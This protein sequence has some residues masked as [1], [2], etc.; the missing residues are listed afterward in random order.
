MTTYTWSANASGSWG[1]GADWTNQNDGTTGTPPSDLDTALINEAGITVTVGTLVAATAYILDTTGATLSVAGGTLTTE[2]L[3][4]F[5]GNVTVSAGTYYAG[6]MGAVF[7]QNLVQ[8]GG[9]IDAVTGALI[10]NDGSTLSGTLAGAGVLDF[11]GPNSNNYIDTGFK[12]NISSIEVTAGA[13]LGLNANF[14]FTHNLTVSNST[15]DLFGHTLTDSGAFALSGIAGDGTIADTGTLTLGTGN[16]TET[17]DDGLLL[18]VTGT[19][20]QANTIYLGA[21]D[22]GAKVMIGKTGHYNING[23]WTVGDPSSV[24]SISNLGVLAK[25]GGG[26]LAQIDTQVTSSATIAAN[27]GEL[28]LDGLVNSI[29]GTVSGAGTF[30]LGTVNGYG[31]TTFKAGLVLS[32][33]NLHQASGVLVLNSAQNYAGD[34]NM[35]GGVLNL[36]AAAA[37]LT[38]AAGSS[39][40]ADAGTITGYGGTLVLDGPAEI[41]NVTIG[42]PDKIDV[43][44]TLTQT[45]LVLLGQSSHPTVN[46]AAGAS[47]RIDADSSIIGQYGLIKNAGVLWDRN[48]SSTATIQSQINSTGTIIAD[49]TLQLA[50]LGSYLHGTLAGS[51]VIDFANASNGPGL[52]Y[53]EAGLSIQVAALDVSSD[54]VLAANQSDAR[55]VSQYA[56]TIDLSGHAFALSGTTSLDGGL[57]SDGGTLSSS[58][59]TTIGNYTVDAGA[60]LLVSGAADQTGGLQL[61]DQNG[62][63]TLSVSATGAYNVLD[64]LNIGGNG[65]VIIAGQF[66]DSGSTFSEIDASVTLATTG[67]LAANDQTLTLTNG[68]R[69]AGTLAGAG[70]IALS[71]GTFSLAAGLALD[72]AT[73]E[74]NGAGTALL[75]ANQTYGGDLR[76]S[77]GTLNLGGDTFTLTGAALLGNNT[78]LTGSGTLV[79]AG[80]TTL[81]ASLVQGSAVLDITHAAQQLSIVSVGNAFGGAESAATLAISAGGTD[82]LDASA[83]IQG[84]G[85]LSVAASGSLIANG[86]AISQITTSVVDNGVIA[87]NHGDLQ[88]IGSI[89]AGSTGMFSIG[90]S[91]ELDFLGN[92]SGASSTTISFATGGSG[93]LAIDDIKSFAAT[94]ANFAVHDMIQITGLSGAVTGTYANASD[95]QILVAD[96]SGNSITLA[97]STAQNLA[98][99]TFTDTSNV[100]TLTHT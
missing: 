87:A 57:L 98:A 36:N 90:G 65:A 84:D 43:N 5:N 99:F 1:V 82:T 21:A 83:S 54:V 62:A 72:S 88:I 50:S 32:V 61:S 7:N 63:G 38:L 33:A 20:I 2:H 34:W 100:A 78:F 14:S 74:V 69:F 77:G 40:S 55:I 44:G 13:K 85:T 76:T 79:A 75:L 45:G 95:T 68:G 53:L 31:Q 23:N 86:N 26:K 80:T 27:I 29:A 46:I 64:N 25:T 16:A 8:T 52:T 94:I 59:Q 67:T 41:G 42:G 19:V 58:G 81:L 48:G 89:S 96:S 6:G 18:N 4:T 71:A 70:A 3:A 51:G 47:W 56:G 9:T 39:F 28:Q 24:G 92:A 73:L 49:S 11:N 66:T 17:L 37:V 97:F 60:T 30:G 15:L 12:C 10:I 35:S 93:L 91:A 22:S